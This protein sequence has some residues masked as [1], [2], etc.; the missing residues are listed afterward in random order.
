METGS[1]LVVGYRSPRRDHWSRLLMSRLFQVVYKVY[2]RVDLKDLSSP[3]LLI[4]RDALTRVINGNL[5]IL[6]QGFWWEFYAR[7]AAAN[8]RI[9]QVPVS[10]RS[11]IS[12][13]T[14]V[15][16]PSAVPRIAYEHI[17]GLARLK[18]ELNA[19]GR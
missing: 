13:D 19:T 7:A 14:Q 11:R 3:Y 2:F 18:A 6:K 15:Y 17:R 4:T 1:D 5:G 8:L 9:T 10:H 16:K 12:G